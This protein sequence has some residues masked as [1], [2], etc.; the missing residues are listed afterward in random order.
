MRVIEVQCVAS[1]SVD[2][3]G[4]GDTKSMRGSEHAGLWFPTEQST[5]LPGDPRGGFP[6]TGDCKTDVIEQATGAFVHHL[7]GHVGG[8]C[9]P[10]EVEQGAS[11]DGG[12]VVVLGRVARYGGHVVCITEYLSVVQTGVFGD[13]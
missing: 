3:R 9:V 2:K 13:R 6:G 5:L 1:D 10:H 7:G 8:G 12:P 4:V 11:L